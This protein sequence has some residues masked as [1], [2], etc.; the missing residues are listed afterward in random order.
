MLPSK[1]RLADLTGGPAFGMPDWG[2]A[3]MLQVDRTLSSSGIRVA[4]TGM[5]KK[6]TAARAAPSPSARKLGAKKPRP[7]SRALDIAPA[8]APPPITTKAFW[9]LMD[10]WAIPDDKAL[11]MLGNRRSLTRT[12]G[13]PRFALDADEVRRLGY[14]G[15]IGTALEVMFGEAGPWLKQRASAL[16]FQGMTP[17]DY[18]IARGL[19]GLAE[20]HRFLA[21]WG[22]SQA[23][24]S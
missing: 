14:L 13:R 5:A 6:A 2:G 18:M 11:Q 16:P 20:V 23:L 4:W 22:L 17:L 3:P 9:P 15:E 21:R 8:A 1:I 12:G 24:G 7:R 19:P 10:R